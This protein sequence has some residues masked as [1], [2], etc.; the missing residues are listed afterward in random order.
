MA[1]YWR[2]DSQGLISGQSKMQLKRPH[3]LLAI[4]QTPGNSLPLSC[5]NHGLI[6]VF[7]GHNWMNR[8]DLLAIAHNNSELN[9]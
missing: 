4:G 2:L 3:F 5:V 7:P 9:R 6:L 1:I 8:S